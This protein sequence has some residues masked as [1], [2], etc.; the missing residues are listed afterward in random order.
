MLPA[1]PASKVDTP[2]TLKPFD[3]KLERKTVED[4]MYNKRRE[5][6]RCNNINRAN[7]VEENRNET[8]TN[9]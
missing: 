6:R 5:R 2:K 1:D 9:V 7:G 8:E 4:K 3:Q